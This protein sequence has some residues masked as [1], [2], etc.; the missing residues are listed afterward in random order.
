[1][2]A[3]QGH[4]AELALTREGGEGG[5][6]VGGEG[7]LAAEMVLGGVESAGGGAELLGHDDPIP[8]EVPPLPAQRE[9]SRGARIRTGDLTDPNHALRWAGIRENPVSMRLGAEPEIADALR[10]EGDYGEFGHWIGVVP[11]P[12]GPRSQPTEQLRR[13]ALVPRGHPRVHGDRATGAA[14]KL[15]GCLRAR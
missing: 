5:S 13:A 10:L 1:V 4:E 2:L 8:L 7:R 9:S 3:A 15:T 11:K 14:G 6:G 12:F